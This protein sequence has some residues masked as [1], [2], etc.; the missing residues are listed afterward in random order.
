MLFLKISFFQHFRPERAISS[1]FIVYFQQWSALYFVAFA[2]KERTGNRSSPVPRLSKN[3]VFPTICVLTTQN[4]SRPKVPMR[5]LSPSR[6]IKTEAH[7]PGFYAFA[8]QTLFNARCRAITWHCENTLS[9]DVFS[10]Q[11]GP[12]PREVRVTIV[13]ASI[14]TAFAVGSCASFSAAARYF[15][16]VSVGKAPFGY[17]RSFSAYASPPTFCAA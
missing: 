7:V 16:T 1:L 9:T 13:S 10:F 17:A 14:V 12:Q 2:D 15:S 11:L 8:Q 4:T 3:F 6:S 5:K